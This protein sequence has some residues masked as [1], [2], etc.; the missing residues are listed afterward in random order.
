MNEID[1][2]NEIP[3]G[4]H[5]WLREY[6]LKMQEKWKET[7]EIEPANKDKSRHLNLPTQRN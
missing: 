2:E 1:K 7:K 5:K 4:T 6:R 3:F